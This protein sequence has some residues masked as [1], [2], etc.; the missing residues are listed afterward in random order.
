M[1]IRDRPY[2]R[3]SQV[4]LNAHVGMNEMPLRR[5]YGTGRC[6]DAVWCGITGIGDNMENGIGGI[7]GDT[8][9]VVKNISTILYTVCPTHYN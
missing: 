4:G 2:T 6:S 5:L 3:R 1:C 7:A 9:P 8:D